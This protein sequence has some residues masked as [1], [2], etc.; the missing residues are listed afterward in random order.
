VGKWPL[1]GGGGEPCPFNGS[2][3]ARWYYPSGR[4]PGSEQ[5]PHR[6]F[7]EHGSSVSSMSSNLSLLASGTR[8]R[9]RGRPGP[10]GMIQHDPQTPALPLC[11]WQCQ[12]ATP[13]IPLEPDSRP[14]RP[15]Y[16]RAKTPGSRGA[17]QRRARIPRGALLPLPVACTCSR[18]LGSGC[19]CCGCPASASCP[20]RLRYWQPEEAPIRV[21]A[22]KI[23]AMAYGHLPA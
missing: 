21:P 9:R 5:P 6:F 11:H 10:G 23:K 8:P 14:G 2:R 18:G 1:P 22:M 13:D 17:F 15:D 3:G 4:R 16:S 20:S 19:C 7:W 12:R